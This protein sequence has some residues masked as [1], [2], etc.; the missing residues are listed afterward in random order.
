MTQ[1]TQLSYT[2]SLA[3]D[4]SALGLRRGVSA[5]DYDAPASRPVQL[6]EVRIDASVPPMLQEDPAME[7]VKEIIKRA[8][9]AATRE[10]R[11]LMEGEA[12]RIQK[13]GK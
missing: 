4:E 2:T 8:I 7:Q 12:E 6:F 5:M 1:N 11:D 3:F 13:L 9:E 10:V